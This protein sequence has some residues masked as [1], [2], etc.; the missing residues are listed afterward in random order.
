MVN[1]SLHDD[2]PFDWEEWGAHH[3]LYHFAVRGMSLPTSFAKI[4]EQEMEIVI[5][6]Y[7]FMLA[8]IL[9]DP[10]ASRECRT[11]DLLWNHCWTRIRDLIYSGIMPQWKVEVLALSVVGFPLQF[12]SDLTFRDLEGEENE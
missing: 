7:L 9:G 10:D 4:S 12:D 8:K 6:E 1:D 5:K 11:Y 3:P 2:H